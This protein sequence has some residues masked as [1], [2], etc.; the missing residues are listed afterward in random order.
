MK[1]H[2]KKSDVPVEEVIPGIKRQVLVYDTN[3]MLVVVNFE[4]GVVAPAHKHPH[5]QVTYVEK[6]VF[7]V[8]IDGKSEILKQGDGFVIPSNA[9]HGAKCIEAGV[10]IDTFSPMR[11]DFV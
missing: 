7:E 3:L 6:G 4:K 5:Q 10:L 8:E 2:I 1:T 9:M 11:E